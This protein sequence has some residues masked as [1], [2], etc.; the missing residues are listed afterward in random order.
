MKMIIERLGHLGDGIAAGP[1]FVP[2]V[3]PG[4]EIEGDVEGDRIT[5]T[6]I[7]RPS[8][9]RVSAPCAHYKSCGGCNLMHASDSFV[10]DW[11]MDVIRTALAAQ[12]LTATFRPVITS[13]PQSRR[14]ATF[15]ARR[16]KKGALVG[17][18]GRASDTLVEVPG[19]KLLHPDLIAILPHLSELTI[20]GASR[21]AVLTIAVTQS[22]GGID[23]AANG[24]K[25]LDQSLFSSLAEFAERVDL[26]RLAW[27]G[28]VVMTRRP[29]SQRFGRANVVPPS[30][31]FLQATADGE[32]ALVDTVREAVGSAKRIVDLFAGSGTFAIPLSEQAEVHAVESEAAMLVALD[33]GWRQA[34]GLHR[35]STETRDLFRRPLLP[36]EFKKVSAVVIDPPRAG[37]EAQMRE[38]AAAGVPIVAAVSCNPV[39]FA[40]DAKILTDAGYNIDWVQVVDQ[41]RW[42]PHVELVARFSR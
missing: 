36:D 42:S 31:S 8:P 10:A 39:T 18:H 1:L 30:G 23:L 11:K 16:T 24:G 17:F 25:E 7:T 33:A 27:N 41:F 15:G 28:E 40:R 9:D 34:E 12:G 20:L 19:C 29:A 22:E 35:I 5:N 6:R 32:T 14:R 4:E 37:A 38:L 26:A 13:A 2:M 3:L 21:K